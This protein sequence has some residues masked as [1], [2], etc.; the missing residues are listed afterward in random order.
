MNANAIAPGIARCPAASVQEVIRADGDS[1]RQPASYKLDAYTF[2]GDQDIP[3]ER[4]TS[5]EFFKREM[6]RMWPRTWQW[7]CREE[8]IPS[9][10]DYYEFRPVRRGSSL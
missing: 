1:D 7:A 2:L 9:A 8:H 4:Y 10:G 6:D 5:P 3:F